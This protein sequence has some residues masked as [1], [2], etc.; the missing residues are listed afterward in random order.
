MCE[1]SH[2]SVDYSI[3]PWMQVGSVNKAKAQNQ[4]ETLVQSLLDQDIKVEILKQKKGL[5]D[6]VFA[7]DQAI[8]KNNKVVISNFRYRQRR[9][10]AKIYEGWFH[11]HNFQINSLPQGIFFEGGGETLWWKDS[12]LVGT[13][14]RTSKSALPHLQK[15]LDVKIHQL[16]LTN[17]NFYHLDT[18]LFP[19]NNEI[20]FYYP[21]AFST[22]SKKL[23][24]KLTRKLIPFT[25]K[26]AHNFAANSLTTDHH[27]VLQKGNPGFKNTL[28]NLGYKTIEV[29]T[30][31]FIKAGGAAHCLVSVIKEEYA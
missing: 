29:D 9:A 18:C 16:E 19:L 8:I 2:F 30:S 15:L 10:E 25:K 13:G 31:E 17:P 23:L 1:P 7:A 24:S 12:L 28:N 26:E 6:M 22:K 3:N 27:V 4:W 11:S 21:P 5:P 20:I 14:F